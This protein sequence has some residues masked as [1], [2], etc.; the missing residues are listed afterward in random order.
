MLLH[1][2]IQSMSKAEK[3]YFKLYAQIGQKNTSKYVNL[4]DLM[5][6]Q[7]TYDEQIIKTK[8]FSAND[9]N[10]L[11]EKLLDARH[12]M[13]LHKSVDAELR[14]FLDYFSILHEK[15]HWQLLSKYIRKAK[16]IAQ[17]NER[18]NVLLEILTWEQNLVFKTVKT[19]FGQ[20]INELIKEKREVLKRLNNE[21]EYYD[22][23]MCIDELLVRDAKLNKPETQKEFDS[24]YQSPLLSDDAKPLSKRAM[25]DYHYIR[26]VYNNLN[27]Q[28]E[29]SYHEYQSILDLFDKHIFLFYLQGYASFYVKIYFWEKALGLK[30]NKTVDTALLKISD[31]PL[32]TID[33]SYTINIQNLTYCVRALNKAEGEY[34]IVQAKKHWKDYTKHIKETRLMAFSYTVMAFYCLFEDWEN[35]QIWLNKVTAI[36]RVSDRKDIQ[37]AARLWQ[38]II[39]YELAPYDSDKHIQTAYKYFVR[40]EHYF[41]VE[42]QILKLFRDLYKAIT[43][44]E[45]QAIWQLMI[46]FID[47]KRQNGDLLQ[48]GL[49]N[50]Q[51]WCES[52]IARMS[53]I[54]VIQQQRKEEPV[55]YI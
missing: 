3:R 15:R 8:G 47:A 54:H 30:L 26:V 29:Q 22:L 40:N 37:V 6:K 11:L 12:T 17:E 19:D 16:Q 5:N 27:K 2:L 31:L 38:L 51:L 28:Y 55:M 9:K 21:L 39:G 36:H 34:Q 33:A 1:E 23:S 25:V 20:K 44:Q 42:Q 14:L 4:F 50:L 18:F 43:R 53:T 7:S 24:L 13:Q 52:K 45:K 41:E 35:A 48:R 10:L 46:D 32:Q 49:G